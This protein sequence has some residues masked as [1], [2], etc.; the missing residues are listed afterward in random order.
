[1]P[2][3]ASC[4]LLLPF[5]YPPLLVDSLKHPGGE[6]LCAQLERR[7]GLGEPRVEGGQPSDAFCCS[8]QW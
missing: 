5:R 4:T 8:V 2:G 7:A 3:T 1:M 6:T